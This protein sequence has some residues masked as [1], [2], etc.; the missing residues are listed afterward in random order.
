MSSKNIVI[1]VL[2]VLSKFTLAQHQDV[3]EKSETYKGKKDQSADT[4]SLL[5]AFK[6]GQT[7]GHFRYFLMATDNARGLTDYYANAAGGGLR[8]ESGKFKGFQMAVSGFYL[9]NIGSSDLGI[10]DPETGQSNR[11]EIGLFD[12]ENPYNFKDI[13]RIEELQLKYNYKQSHFTFGR[14]LINTPFIN[15]QDG[16]MRPTGVEGLWMEI[17]EV[18]KVKIEAGWI[19]AISPRG[20]TK[21]YYTRNSVGINPSGLNI[22][23]TQSDYFENIDS[24]GVGLLGIT[25]NPKKWLEIKLWDTYFENVMNTAMIQTDF[26]KI[27]KNK[28]QFYFGLQFIRQDAVNFGGN[29]DPSKT[30]VNANKNSMVIGSRL[31]YENKNFNASIN[32]THIAKNG[33][34]LM[35]REWGRDPFYTFMPRERNEGYG[36]LHAIVGRISYNFPKVNVKTNLAAGF[37]RLPDVYN[38][39]LNKYG[40]P[41]Y[42]QINADTRYS[43]KGFLNGLDAQLLV[44]GKINQGS[45]HNNRR[46]EFNKVNMVNYN[47]VL[48]YHF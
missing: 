38:F 23:G 41:S 28:S 43:F 30:Y 35:P 44:V 32:Y 24:K 25:L 12:I 20:T 21:W 4:L 45:L 18:K 7:N 6:N 40:M 48:N 1:L 47:L 26:K 27:N 9:F 34:Y 15:L 33:R 3:H 14:Q 36:D 22:D 19:Y 11:Y 13:D 39:E 31:G 10:K 37:F 29:Q 42:I 17:N 2:I 16:R 8:Y 5:S 46:F